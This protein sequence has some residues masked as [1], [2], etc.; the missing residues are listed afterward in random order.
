MGRDHDDLEAVD[1]LELVRLGVRRARHAGE[2]AVHAEVVL[3][4]DRGDRLV[5]LFHLH[6]FLRLDGL[7]QAVRPAPAD[8]RAARELVDDDHLAVLDD[9]VDVALEEPMSAQRRGQVM[10][11]ANVRRVVEALALGEDPGAREQLLDFLVALL[12]EVRLLLLL[13]DRVVARH[14]QL[15]ARRLGR[16]VD[17]DHVQAALLRLARAPRPSTSCRATRP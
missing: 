12:R 6:A 14:E 8:H 16:R 4:G 17:L 5:L 10:H 11:E 1:L 2:L 9:V 7:M 3:E 15:R 13:V